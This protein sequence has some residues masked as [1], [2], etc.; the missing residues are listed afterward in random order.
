MPLQETIQELKIAKEKNVSAWNEASKSIFLLDEQS[1]KIEELS[2]QMMEL[3]SHHSTCK[4]HP[5]ESHTLNLNTFH[6]IE[7][8]EHQNIQANAAANVRKIL[9]RHSF[10]V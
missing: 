3:K 5:N 2:N 10:T 6:G 8:A 9:K 7:C 1:Q 4:K